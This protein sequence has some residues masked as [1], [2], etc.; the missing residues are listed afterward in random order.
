MSAQS[1]A[2]LVLAVRTY[3]TELFHAEEHGE[4]A[5]WPSD[6]ERLTDWKEPA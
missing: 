5:P 4:R 1:E 6:L 2:A 3:L